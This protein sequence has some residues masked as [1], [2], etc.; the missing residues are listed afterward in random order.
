MKWSAIARVTSDSEIVVDFSEKGGP[1]D[2]TA[3]WDE[4]GIVFPDGNKWTKLRGVPD[5]LAKGV[6]TGRNTLR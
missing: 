4:N 6:T 5:K 2:V 3:K 1:A